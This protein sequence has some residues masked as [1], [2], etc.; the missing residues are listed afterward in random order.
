MPLRIFLI[1]SLRLIFITI[2]RDTT[3]LPI[4]RKL[5]RNR[6]RTGSS[7]ASRIRRERKREMIRRGRREESALII[8]TRTSLLSCGRRTRP[9]QLWHSALSTLQPSCST[10]IPLEPGYSTG[11]ATLAS[12]SL[13]LLLFLASGSIAPN[14]SRV[15]SLPR[16]SSSRSLAH[17]SAE[18]PPFHCEN[19]NYNRN[20]YSRK[21][22]VWRLTK[23]RR[24]RCTPYR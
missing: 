23:P 1:Y 24:V 6:R 12:N 18:I 21:S 13:F 9:L 17:F 22:F 3:A 20:Y 14:R 7:E 2:H 10:R 16:T 15:S 19:F 5:S 8:C 11:F 4:F